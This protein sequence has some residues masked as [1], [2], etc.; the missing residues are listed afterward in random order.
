MAADAD[1]VAWASENGIV[2]G[3][4]E[5]EFAPDD[6]ITREQMAAMIYRYSEYKGASPTEAEAMQL[7]YADLADISDYAAEAVMYCNLTGIM[8]GDENNNFAPLS[9]ATRAEAA[10]VFERVHGTVK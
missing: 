6:A 7:D 4:S 8:I 2:N 1:A 5:A 10:A 3:V 9:N